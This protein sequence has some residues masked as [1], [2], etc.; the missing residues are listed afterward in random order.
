MVT[1]APFTM[2]LD[3]RAAHAERR[4]PVFDPATGEVLQDAPDCTLVQTE[5]AVAGARRAQLLWQR[6]PAEARR[7]ALRALCAALA[8]A[9][10]ALQTVLCLEVGKPL[11]LSR[12][13]LLESFR[14]SRRH[15]DDR[16]L[17][18]RVAIDGKRRV[19]TL[20]EPLGVV[21]LRA[22]C[23]DPVR[24]VWPDAMA[25]LHAGNSVIVVAAPTAPLTLLRFG[26]LARACLPAGV[27]SVV[28]GGEALGP[29]LAAHPAVARH[30][31]AAMPVRHAAALVLDDADA[32]ATI[33]PLFRQAFC[34]DRG[35]R[36]V[37]RIVY[38]HRDLYA[39]VANAWADLARSARLGPGRRAGIEIGPLQNRQAHADA[40]RH[41]AAAGPLSY[42]AG[43]EVSRAP[44]YFVPP[45]VVDDPPWAAQARL[46]TAPC[47]V[48]AL[49]KYSDADEVLG[50]ID[51]RHASWA[52]SVWSL[53][54]ERARAIAD[55]LKVHATAV[56]L[57]AAPSTAA[58]QEPQVTLSRFT[59]PRVRMEPLMAH[60]HGPRDFPGAALFISSR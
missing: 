15:L 41:F 11:P 31:A 34:D 32:A 7:G 53:D 49:V 57:P 25:A 9:R 59:R 8:D 39:R 17:R 29:M 33:A 44:G 14:A 20:L 60:G 52:V 12:A 5:H 58:V 36:P 48:V 50:V 4:M 2:T 47:P 51:A 24:S 18:P 6:C 56:N 27:L 26:E 21:V 46:A 30:A 13:E 19:R 38:V 45:T 40:A 37:L 1:S 28:S 3:G 55:R 35:G 23:A 10:D 22:D 43:G 54:D 42:L 16:L